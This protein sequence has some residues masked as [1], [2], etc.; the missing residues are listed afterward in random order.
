MKKH[1]SFSSKRKGNLLFFV[2]SMIIFEE[3]H[4]SWKVI[5]WI[6]HLMIF[7]LLWEFV[8][9]FET[10]N[11]NFVAVSILEK[12]VFGVHK[13][14]RRIKR[15]TNI[16]RRPFSEKNL[17]DPSHPAWSNC[18]AHSSHVSHSLEPEASDCEQ[19]NKNPR[20]F[21]IPRYASYMCNI[22]KF[23]TNRD[24]MFQSAVCPFQGIKTEI[25][26]FAFFIMLAPFQNILHEWFGGAPWPV[27][28]KRTTSY[29][30]LRDQ[31]DYRFMLS[32]CTILSKAG[33]MNRCL[34]TFNDLCRDQT[35]R[36]MSWIKY[37][38]V[39]LYLHDEKK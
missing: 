26:A 4:L 15:I 12:S 32:F 24:S 28:P 14:L 19:W 39:L 38:I 7:C 13:I 23:Q 31:E 2:F 9:E 21:S 30:I 33:Y 17:S 29:P 5:W 18:Y 16:L 20:E 1:I 10:E 22:I 37:Q 36:V 11:L 34:I 6:K 3:E 25:A 35:R 8:L 27:S